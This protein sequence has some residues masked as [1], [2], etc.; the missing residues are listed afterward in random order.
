MPSLDD[1]PLDRGSGP[2]SGEFRA[3]SAP[4]ARGLRIVFVAVAAL[5]VAGA[6]YFFYARTRSTAS[7]PSA[8]A[9]AASGASAGATT[10]GS[11]A[12]ALPPLA[13]MDP[14]VRGLLSALTA[15]PE[16]LKWLATDDL[17]GSM[18]TAI[19]RLA[20]GESPARDLAVLR[21]EQPFTTAGRDGALRV[22][23]TGYARY[24]PLVQAVT[25]IDTARLAA[26]FTTLRPRLA[27]AYAAQGHPEG[28]F[29]DALARALGTIVSTPDVPADAAL[30]PGVGGYQY[31]DPAWQ[32]LPPAQRHLLRMGP[33]HVRAVRDAT[34][35]FAA[36]LG[37]TPVTP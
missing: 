26:A 11:P 35:R 17:L 34:S 27:E 28:G 15:Q 24:T 13:E 6:A 2:E 1:L 8:G 7:A 12:I 30:V 37:V 18:A 21:P 14:V 10:G 23:P 19:D 32:R 16:L 31:D 5:A 4:S 25:T 20:R 22:D 33:D 3:T 9:T 36:A 29:D